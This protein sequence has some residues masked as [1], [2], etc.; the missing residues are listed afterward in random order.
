MLII[1]FCNEMEKN[2]VIIPTYNE[3][4]NVIVM[5][6]KVFSIHGKKFD[7]LIVDDSSP[8][9]TADLVKK[10]IKKHHS[11]LYLLKEIKRLV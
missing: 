2:L 10:L 4:E 1:Y 7:I 3:A 9:G 8:D 6:E 11:Q 5:I